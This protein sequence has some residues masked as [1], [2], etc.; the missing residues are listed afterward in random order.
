MQGAAC[1][2]RSLLDVY[3]TPTL[4]TGPGYVATHRDTGAWALE[5]VRNA[6]QDEWLEIAQVA[7]I[8]TLGSR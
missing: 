3:A 4:R 1:Q 7:G 2:T 5:Q 6:T 8:M